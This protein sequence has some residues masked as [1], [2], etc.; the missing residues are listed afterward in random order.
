MHVPLSWLSEYAPF[1]VDPVDRVAV[2][3]LGGVLDSLGLVVESTEFVGDVLSGV[4]LAQVLAIEPIEGADRIRKVAVSYGASDPAQIVC[5]AHNFAVGDVVAL[6]TIGT[7]LP[8]GFR[9]E[10]RTMLGVV[11]EGMLCSG[12]ELG[13]SD[14]AEGLLIVASPGADGP[15]P[16]GIVLGGGL[17]EHLGIEPDVVFEITVEPNRP[18]ALSVVG[19]ARDLAA[20]L[21]VPFSPPSPTVERSGP[22]ASTLA[23]VATT[24]P[25]AC[26]RILGR[27]LSGC[28]P[29]ASPPKVRRRLE[30]AGMRPINSIVDASN[31]VMLELGQPTHPYD[32]DRLGG[33]GISV[34]LASAGEPL[35]TLD[36][37]TRTLGIARDRGGDLVELAELVVTDA[38]DRPVGLA[39]VMGG[40]DSE[41]GEET[42]DVLLEV[43]HFDSMVV[44][45]VAARYEL[46]TEAAHRFWRGTDPT[47]MDLAADRFCELVISASIAAGVA[48]PTVAPGALEDDRRPPADP[49]IVL[50]TSRV[51]AIL[52]TELAREE[53]ASL[54]APIGFTT[55]PVGED[56]AVVVP[57]FRSDVTLEVDL[58]EEVARHFGYDAISG[59]LRRSP[60]PGRLSDRQRRRRI[61]RRILTGVGAYEAWT[62]SIVDPSVEAEIGVDGD[63][64]VVSN[65][66]V[67]SDTTLRTQLLPGLLAALGRNDGRRN[68]D[69]RLFEIGRVFSRSGTDDERPIEHEVVGIVL[70]EPDDDARGAVEVARTILDGLGI[71]ASQTAFEPF[72]DRDDPASSG[73]H[74][75][76][77][78]YLVDVGS[79]EDAPEV[80][81]VVGEIDPDVAERFSLRH[82][83]IGWI[84]LDLDH[85]FHVSRRDRR[86]VAVSEFPSSD[87][88]LDF[89]V[90]EEVPADRLER[91]ISDAVGQ[92]LESVTLVDAFRGPSVP[93]GTRS[94]TYRLRLSSIDHTLSTEEIARARDACIELVESELPARLRT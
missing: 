31:Y 15:L 77:S 36:K 25:W 10:R 18:D 14:D 20:K 29:V 49:P 80:I 35:V 74:P 81:G 45:R 33:R 92:M 17:S 11:S 42:T 79:T 73:C 85:L 41:I 76:R 70:A 78:V 23:S 63:P 90:D 87:L 55:T 51:N 50:R 28:T 64:V 46:R 60:T 12:P 93:E 3:A 59:S 39:G 62:S 94:L 72:G 53:I 61:L 69:V 65:P 40:A 2:R 88:D 71:D 75:T 91:A 34:R 16:E 43:A 27:V 30:L 9:I 8:G 38:R 67:A 57:G 24:V 86:A 13:L 19:I 26:D 82:R 68:G 52:G 89:I 58:I 5:G 1:G 37:V 32:L 66:I 4:V 47:G 7:E 44:G 56:L 48:P 21:G 83:R 6:A 22:E 84:G 54:I